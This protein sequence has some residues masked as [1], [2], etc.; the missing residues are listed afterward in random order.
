MNSHMNISTK[1][2]KSL[3]L[4]GFVQIQDKSRSASFL[5]LLGFAMVLISGGCTTLGPSSLKSERINYNLAL[6]ITNDE[7]ML[8]NLVRLKYRDTPILLTVNSIASQYS[9]EVAAEAGAELET[10]PDNDLFSI[11]GGLAY[12]TRPTVTYTPLQGEEFMQRFLSPISLDAV[13]LLYRSGWTVKRLFRLTVQRLNN[14]KN[15]PR[16]S[17]PTPGHAPQYK[18]FAQVLDLLN[19]LQRRELLDFVYET[20]P[21]GE[22]PPRLAMQIAENAW[23]DPQTLK[24]AEILQLEKDKK[25]YPLKY[26][27]VEHKQ[28][29][30]FAHLRVETRSLLGI[31][32]YL[33]QSVEVP[34]RDLEGGKVTVT[35]YENGEA[36]EW[37]KVLGG[38][39]NIKA[40][41]LKPPQ[42]AVAVRYRGNWFYVDDSDLSSKSTFFLLS[43]LFAMQS[44][45]VE[46]IV[47]V[48]TLPVGR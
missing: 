12:S 36:F 41:Q 29:G 46:T 38:I 47:P 45:K 18:D 33:S 27:M 30:R 44:G 19:R 14:V 39:F 28:T 10:G 26:Q 5:L 9:F 32:F 4:E 13:S 43:Q 42:A 17:G 23:D 3:R 21:S 48:L 1:R 37:S 34:E 35:R 20:Y 25:H 2:R 6:Q 15:A 7:Q 11:G 22:R 31:M 40:S 16:A 8:L 24:L